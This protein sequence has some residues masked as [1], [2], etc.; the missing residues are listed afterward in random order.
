MMI[1]ILVT[2]AQQFYHTKKSDFP[3]GIILRRILD[4]MSIMQYISNTLVSTSVLFIL[5]MYNMLL[6]KTRW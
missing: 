5:T 6:C 4:I 2:F 1:L 3:E